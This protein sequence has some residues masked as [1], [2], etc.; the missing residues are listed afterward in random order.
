MVHV[1]D[2]R[3]VHTTVPLADA[4]EVSGFPS[5]V[6]AQ[7]VAL[8]PEERRELLSRKDSPVYS[9]EMDLSGHE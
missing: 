7:I 5:D 1:Y 9:G 6:R 2:D 3:I 4:P 8:S